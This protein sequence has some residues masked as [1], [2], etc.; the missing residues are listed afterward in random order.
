MTL[1]ISCN[2]MSKLWELL[3]FVPQMCCWLFESF[4]SLLEVNNHAQALH[5]TKKTIAEFVRV[6]MGIITII[7]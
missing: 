3:T 6:I 4:D 5:S 7:L 2:A 1:C